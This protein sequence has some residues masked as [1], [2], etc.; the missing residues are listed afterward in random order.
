MI[1]KPQTRL[2]F[3][4]VNHSFACHCSE[5]QHA[6]MICTFVLMYQYDAAADDSDH[7]EDED[8]DGNGCHFILLLLLTRFA[9]SQ[10]VE[11]ESTNQGPSF[12]VGGAKFGKRFLANPQHIH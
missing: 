8:G 10:V 5:H 4:S 7:D 2:L 3:L 11:A 1:Q 6:R 12:T 9:C